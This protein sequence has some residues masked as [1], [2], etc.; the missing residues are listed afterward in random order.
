MIIYKPSGSFFRDIHHFNRSLVIRRLITYV[1]FYG[2]AVAGLAALF[3]WADW[4]KYLKLDGL[5]SIFS[6]L[7]VVLSILLVF[8]TNTAYD[9]W[10]EGL[11]QSQ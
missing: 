1:L 4:S 5:S 3:I 10:W 8:R 9:R 11:G 2:L 6:F 7:G